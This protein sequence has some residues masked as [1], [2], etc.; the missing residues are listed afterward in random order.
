MWI[1]T[2]GNELTPPVDIS[3]RLCLD[4]RPAPVNKRGIPVEKILRTYS[5][6]NIRK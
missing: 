3:S 2:D 4:V 6:S 1:E 5:H